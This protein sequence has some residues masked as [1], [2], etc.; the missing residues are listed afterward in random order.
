MI[1]IPMS[2]QNMIRKDY[3]FHQSG[4]LYLLTDS[5]LCVY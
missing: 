5:S 1:Q 4:M 2:N 3:N